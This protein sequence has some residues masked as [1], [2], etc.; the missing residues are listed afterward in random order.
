MRRL[1]LAGMLLGC[2]TTPSTPEPAPYTV[3][4]AQQRYKQAAAYCQQQHQQM[5]Q[6]SP[7]VTDTSFDGCMQAANTNLQ[8]DYTVAWAQQR[9]DQAAAYCQQ[10]HQQM[11]QRSPEV[12]DTSFGGC[13]QAANNNLQLD[14]DMAHSGVTPQPRP[15]PP[16][17]PPPPPEPLAPEGTV[18]RAQQNYNLAVERCRDIQTFNQILAMGPERYP[19]D[20][21]AVTVCMEQ[22]KTN[23]ELDLRR[24]KQ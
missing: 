21:T 4:W 23:L 12:T 20:P 6:R 24:V 18:K 3:A 13:M 7:E 8:L 16:A 2:A 10:Q 9:Y 22:A 19:L 11:M 14:M 1:L 15:P 17:P 5:M